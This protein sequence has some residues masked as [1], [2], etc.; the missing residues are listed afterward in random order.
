MK[1]PMTLKVNLIILFT[2]LVFAFLILPFFLFQDPLQNV[3]ESL[4]GKDVQTVREQIG[5]PEKVLTLEEVTQ[6]RSGE[7]LLP[8]F[9]P[10]EMRGFTTLEVYRMNNDKGLEEMTTR[11]DA[12]VLYYSES[13]ILTYVG[14]S[15]KHR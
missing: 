15:A 1:G 11:N 13:G 12:L 8:G 10:P 9:D 4:V 14:K 3:A 6:M 7:E 2:F 5:E